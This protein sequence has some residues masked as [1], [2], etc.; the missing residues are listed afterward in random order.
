MCYSASPGFV[1]KTL[2]K[3]SKVAFLAYDV[4]MNVPTLTDHAKHALHK[5]IAYAAVDPEMV[6]SGLHTAI[7]E[8]GDVQEVLRKER[9]SLNCLNEAGLAPLHL[10]VK[11]GNLVAVEEL[12]AAG[13]DVNIMGR[14]RL[15]PLML[16]ED[17][18][19]VLRLL[20]AKCNVNLQ[21]QGGSTALHYACIYSSEGV[22]AAL[23]MAGASVHIRQQFGAQPLK[24]LVRC[25]RTDIQCKFDHLRRDL[26][27]DLEAK[28]NLGNTALLSAVA[29]NNFPLLQC[30]VKA[31]SSLVVSNRHAVNVLHLA[32]G[33]CDE[34]VLSYLLSLQLSNIN[35]EQEDIGGDTPCDNLL[36]VMIT[37]LWTIGDR[38]RPNLSE[39]NAFAELYQ[40]V[41]DRNL[42]HDILC[43]E[44]SLDGL[45]S[46]DKDSS[47]AILSRMIKQKKEWKQIG[48]LKTLQA[49]EGYVRV[50]ELE[51]ASG[52]IHNAIR[53]LKEEIGKS[54]WEIY[55][56]EET[57]DIDGRKC[58]SVSRRTS[59]YEDEREQ[60]LWIL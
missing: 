21:D 56:W 19:I 16:A 34:S 59:I 20:K 39:Q 44:N 30:L 60:I 41:R 23:V 28:D 46:G 17:A 11:Q 58:L 55:D 4:L 8:G 7:L 9:G 37:P 13:A 25:R 42:E 1:I 3:G 53:D 49:I 36:Q 24:A 31:G 18:E 15:T 48:L 14:G 43:L 6:N 27:L 40:D 54:P 29:G 57:V 26:G 51:S 50:S 12:I 22:V 32:A 10:A 35:V 45:A 33:Y 2:K 38:R 47:Q 5:A 52:V